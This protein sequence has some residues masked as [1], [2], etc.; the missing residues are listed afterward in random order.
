MAR[1][2]YRR[3]MLSKI[4]ALL[5][6]CS[7]LFP[8]LCNFLTSCLC[9]LYPGWNAPV[10]TSLSSAAFV[11]TGNFH[12]KNTIYLSQGFTQTLLH[13]YTHF[14]LCWHT[15]HSRC[16]RPLLCVYSPFSPGLPHALLWVYWYFTPALLWLFFTLYS[17]CIHNLLQVNSH[18]TPGLLILCWVF[19]HT[20]LWM[21]S[22][23]TPS[24]ITLSFGVTHT[25]LWLFLTLYSCFTYT[26]LQVYSYFPSGLFTIYSWLTHALLNLSLTL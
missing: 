16:T 1:R 2:T 10:S 6:S 3:T 11:V 15:L 21:Y 4:S 9:Q 20:L 18:F 24:L 19:A 22:Q 26:L 8:T 13:V 5:L 25:L 12:C 7:R 23:R 17:G 14:T